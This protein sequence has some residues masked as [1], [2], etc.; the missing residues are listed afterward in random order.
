MHLWG[1]RAQTFALC[2]TF[3]CFPGKSVTSLEAPT[4]PS[5]SFLQCTSLYSPINL[6]SSKCF[7]WLA[8]CYGTNTS[9][10]P[11]R[12][13]LRMELV[14]LSHCRSQVRVSLNAVVSERGCSSASM[15]PCRDD[16][17][18]LNLT[19]SHS[20]LAL[21]SN[22]AY[23]IMSSFSSFWRN[24]MST[25]HFSTFLLSLSLPWFPTYTHIITCAVFYMCGL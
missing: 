24:I 17:V 12:A 21:L 16:V 25:C 15:S 20:C 6:S 2:L 11:P 5:L 1:S 19:S 22:A 7:K 18:A 14:L 13:I 9:T 4:F 3:S 10:Q 8:R 23:L